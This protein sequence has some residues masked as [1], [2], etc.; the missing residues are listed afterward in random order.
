HYH[1]WVSGIEHGD[2]SVWNLMWDEVD[3]CGVLND[4]DLSAIKG[5]TENRGGERTG[6]LPFMARG[7]LEPNFMEG[8]QERKYM[9]EV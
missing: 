1:L 7:I 8:K 3:N 9:H 2:I 4:F 6:T 5:S